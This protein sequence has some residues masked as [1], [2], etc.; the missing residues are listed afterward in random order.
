LKIF[1]LPIWLVSKTGFCVCGSIVDVL[2]FDGRAN[3]VAG[4]LDERFIFLLLR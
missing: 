1:Y 2:M 3:N 4:L